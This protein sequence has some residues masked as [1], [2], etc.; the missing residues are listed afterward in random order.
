[1][2]FEISEENEAKI[3]EWLAN[4]I[5]PDLIQQQKDTIAEPTIFHTMSWEDGFPYEGAIGG[6]ISY[7]FTPTSLGVIFE[8]EYSFGGKTFTLNLTRYE[9]W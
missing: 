2:K 6:G 9:D 1:M 4:E 7:K 3:D 8:A 5:Y